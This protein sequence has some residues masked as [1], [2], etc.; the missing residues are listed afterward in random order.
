MIVDNLDL[1]YLSQKEQPMRDEFW[2]DSLD[3]Q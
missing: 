3:D 2:L 1:Q